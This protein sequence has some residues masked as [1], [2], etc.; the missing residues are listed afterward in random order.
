[1]ADPNASPGVETG[2]PYTLDRLGIYQLFRD[3][4]FLQEAPAFLFL[5]DIAKAVVA[6]V[7]ESIL[8][9]R[10]QGCGSLRDM[11][12][13]LADPFVRVAVKTHQESPQA[14]LPVVHTISRKLGYRPQPIV[15]YYK[16]T[17]G[18]IAALE[19]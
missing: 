10:C 17:D 6:K 14:L 15:L 18:K 16:G 11:I 12:E 7:T 1:M 2:P 13:P 8:H 9:P 19:F 4:Q 3:R 5:S